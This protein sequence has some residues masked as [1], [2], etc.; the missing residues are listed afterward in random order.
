MGFIFQ[1]YGTNYELNETL[2]SLRGQRLPD[3]SVEIID[4]VEGGEQSTFEFRASEFNQTYFGINDKESVYP[5]TVI[6]KENEIYLKD[7]IPSL[8]FD[9]FIEGEWNDEGFT[10]TFPQPIAMGEEGYGQIIVAYLDICEYAEVLDDIGQN[11]PTYSCAGEDVCREAL[12]K[13]NNDGYYKLEINGEEETDTDKLPRYIIGVTESHND[14]KSEWSGI[15]IG[16][17][18]LAEFNSTPSY[19]PKDVETS[20]WSYRTKDNLYGFVNVGFLNDEIYIQDICPY[21]PE[22]CLKGK[23]I[24]GDKIEFKF[25]QYM[26]ILDRRFVNFYGE[27]KQGYDYNDLNSIIM[28][29]D[30]ESQTILMSDDSQITVSFQTPSNQI[31]FETR[32]N[33]YLGLAFKNQT[34]VLLN[35]KPINPIIEYYDVYNAYLVG[36]FFNIEMPPFDDNQ[37]LLAEENLFY[38]IYING[39]A[40]TFLPEY[41]P[42][43]LESMVD[44]PY[45]F[46]DMFNIY[47]FGSFHQ[48]YI[49][50]IVIEQ[51]GIQLHFKDLADEIHSSDIVEVYTEFSIAP[52]IENDIVRREYYDLNGMPVKVPGKGIYIMKTYHENNNVETTKII[53]Q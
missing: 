40:Y 20:L 7:I 35:G 6:S 24:E 34:G 49:R 11:F 5:V 47:Y 18:N 46:G 45:T 10:I 38:T 43:L 2:Y 8:S 12:F 52:K 9:T 41:Y 27:E 37:Y 51:F 4:L 3:E 29:Y 14:N 31:S 1:I 28:D 16:R 42:G 15:G 32:I 30:P 26:G 39:E 48:I 44:I 53:N 33:Q 13:L 17:L 22:S 21:F 19:I 36:G 23:F 50:D 25:P